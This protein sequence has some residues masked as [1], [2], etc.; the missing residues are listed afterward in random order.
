MGLPEHQC[1]HGKQKKMLKALDLILLWVQLGHPQKVS[2]YPME[3][4]KSGK[5]LDNQIMLS[6]DSMELRSSFGQR[7]Q[8]GTLKR[9]SIDQVLEPVVPLPLSSLLFSINGLFTKAPTLKF[10]TSLCCSPLY[11]ASA[12]KGSLHPHQ[13]TRINSH[14]KKEPFLNWY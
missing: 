14:H 11:S 3:P 13:D 6:G 10:I 12:H 7:R 4:G 2:Q 5:G 8:K 1:Q 9:Q